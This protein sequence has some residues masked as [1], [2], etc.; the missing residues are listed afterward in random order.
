M[1][2]F[3]RTDLVL[4][5]GFIVKKILVGTRDLLVHHGVPVLKEEY[6]RKYARKGRRVLYLAEAGKLMAMFVV[7]YS[8]EPQL[9]KSLK[10]LEKK[11]NDH[12]CAQC[13]PVYK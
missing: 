6:E 13:R 5:H 8:A 11:R 7:S 2:L 3:M 10:K 4:R 1:T 9:K 12:S